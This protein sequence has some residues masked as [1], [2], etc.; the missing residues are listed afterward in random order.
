MNNLAP[1]HPPMELYATSVDVT[2]IV[3][4][5]AL[6][7]MGIWLLRYVVYRLRKRHKQPKPM[8]AEE[9]YEQ[10]C[11]VD[12]NDIA[13]LNLYLKKILGYYLG[14]S[15]QVISLSDRER[16]SWLTAQKVPQMI[17]QD[18]HEHL[19]MGET[20]LFSPQAVSGE[21]AVNYKQKTLALGR[22]IIEN[23]SQKTD[24]YTEQIE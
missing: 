3:V 1:P 6:L 2:A 23:Y 11:S 17:A 5:L 13:S 7:A 10:A 18:Y 4:L 21:S 9:L 22:Q 24:S 14:P 8:N 19:C 12:H 16:L 15:E 20:W